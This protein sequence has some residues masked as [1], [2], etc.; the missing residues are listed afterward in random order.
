M[1]APPEGSPYWKLDASVRETLERS[2][3]ARVQRQPGG[4]WILDDGT[5]LAPEDEASLNLANGFWGASPGSAWEAAQNAG[6][7]WVSMLVRVH[8]RM[9]AIDP[10]L[11]LWEQIQ[12]VRN[13][14]WGGSGGFKVVYRDPALMRRL[15]DGLAASHRGP[16]VARD[17]L[18]G[19]LEH[20]L[21]SSVKVIAHQLG[22]DPGALFDP[23][24]D[25][26]D[27]D[28]W[29]EVDRPG[30]EGLHFCVGREDTKPASGGARHVKLDDVH[31]DWKSPVAGVGPRGRCQYTGA[32]SSLQHWVQAML[33]VAKPVFWFHDTGELLASLCD[34]ERPLPPS[35]VPE[36]DALQAEWQS[37]RFELAVQG[38][39]GLAAAAVCHGRAAALSRELPG[40]S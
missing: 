32:F 25:P 30:G 7:E 34:P 24:S 1:S 2:Y 28:T 37:R 23:E 18:F 14:W 22:S 39:A 38:K 20:Q 40:R 3:R 33:H 9:R 6:P 31:L 13:G 5:R 12:Y 26:P 17:Q 35:L 11:R 21:E 8:E 19:S 15:L 27:A 36:R 16:R 10:T 4:T 29:R